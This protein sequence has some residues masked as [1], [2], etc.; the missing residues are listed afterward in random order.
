MIAMET[1]RL[2]REDFVSWLAK[3]LSGV[4]VKA[5]AGRSGGEKPGDVTLAWARDKADAWP[6]L[7][8]R[9]SQIHD[10]YAFVSTYTKVRPFTAFFRVLPFELISVL[11]PRD[12]LI[13]GIAGAKCVAGAAM[14]E[15]WVASD[16]EADRPKNVLPL[17]L[18]SLSASLGKTVLAG[19]DEAAFDW[20]LKE[21]AELRRQPGDTLRT[22]DIEGASKPWRILLT[23]SANPRHTRTDDNGL[24]ADFLATAL[25]RGSIQPDMLRSLDPL[26]GQVDLM[27]LL[28]ASREERI[29]RFNEMVADLKR[30][31]DRGLRS[32]FVA[33]LMLAIAGNGSFELL[34]SAREF[35]GWLDGAV[36]WFGICAALFEESNVLTYGNSAGRRLVRDFARV[37]NPFTPPRADINSSELR[38]MTNGEAFQLAT[39]APNCLDVELLPNVLSRVSEAAPEDFTRRDETE[40]L[41]RN[42]DEAGYLIDRAR[43]LASGYVRGER[44]RSLFKPTRSRQSR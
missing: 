21:W 13:D 32:E 40:L 17:L 7:S 36:T 26:A 4:P 18:S 39:H 20:V 33:G 15:A 10:F 29:N 12:S 38:F 22:Q 41:L 30:R 16:R 5:N 28:A 27:G 19:Y 11:Q 34:R 6:V 23:A 37:D 43:Q 9:Q 44:Q 31:S 2:N 3:A 24:I 35:D 25:A 1:V 8:V 14:A 42:L